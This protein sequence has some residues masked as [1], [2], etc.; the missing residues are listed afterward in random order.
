MKILGISKKIIKYF[1]VTPVSLIDFLF[2]FKNSKQLISA[3]CF[4]SDAGV[5]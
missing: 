2:P 4:F 3:D 1:P 5:K